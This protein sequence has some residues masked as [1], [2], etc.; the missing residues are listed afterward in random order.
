MIAKLYCCSSWLFLFGTQLSSQNTLCLHL[1]HY[2]VPRGGSLEEVDR[3]QR[4]LEFSGPMIINPNPPV[5]TLYVNKTAFRSSSAKYVSRIHICMMKLKLKYWM[6]L[7]VR[8]C[9][10]YCSFSLSLRW[11]KGIYLTAVQIHRGGRP[12]QEKGFLFSK[13]TFGP[14][15]PTPIC[16]QLTILDSTYNDY[17][18]WWLVRSVLPVLLTSSG[19][20]VHNVPSISYILR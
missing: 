17:R 4:D 20:E 6:W 1:I 19:L 7:L 15:I 18:V 10:C 3:L 11:W 13:V 9:L 5:P 16:I 12:S 14:T 2:S 8:I